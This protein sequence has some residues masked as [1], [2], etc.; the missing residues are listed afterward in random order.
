MTI[1]EC[2]IVGNVT[3]IANDGSL[4][5]TILANKAVTANHSTTLDDGGSSYFGSSKL[6]FSIDILTLLHISKLFFVTRG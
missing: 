1:D 5:D 3:V 2:Y 6:L 4:N